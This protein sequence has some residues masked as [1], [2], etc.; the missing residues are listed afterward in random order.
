M[1]APARFDAAA[2][3]GCQRALDDAARRL[4]DAIG[5]CARRAIQ[6]RRYAAD[7]WQMKRAVRILGLWEASQVGAGS[8]GDLYADLTLPDAMDMAKT[9]WREIREEMSD[10]P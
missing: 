5:I 9:C 1:N 3:A 4:E 6:R 8:F 7:Y 2:A 10:A